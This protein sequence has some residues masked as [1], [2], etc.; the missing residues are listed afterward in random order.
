MRYI[1]RDLWYQEQHT[2]LRDSLLEFQLF[3]HFW[4]KWKRIIKAEFVNNVKTP[5]WQHL[6][7]GYSAT[8]KRQ[9]RLGKAKATKKTKKPNVKQQALQMEMPL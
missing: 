4:G 2:A 3:A 8:K 9:L 7:K 1:N 6:K 5:S